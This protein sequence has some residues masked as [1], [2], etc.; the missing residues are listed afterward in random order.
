MSEHS[1][2]MAIEWVG[3]DEITPADWNVRVGHD[4]EGIAEQVRGIL[5]AAQE[6]AD[7]R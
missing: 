7:A 4:V 3:V 2:G 1:N 5:D 6:P